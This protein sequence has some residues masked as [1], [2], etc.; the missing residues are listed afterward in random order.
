MRKQ[1]IKVFN[2]T[3]G[4]LVLCC[5]I[6]S[7]ADD[8]SDYVSIG[9]NIYE[10]GTTTPIQSAVISTSL[11][12]QTTTSDQNGYFELET[13]TEANYSSTPYTI[14]ITASGYTTYSV[15]H[16][17]GDHPSSQTFYLDPQ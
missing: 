5:S 14:T 13:Q 8:S 7:C 4:F 16:T 2:I 12:S 10:Q 1:F 9:G 6:T 15:Y 17:W 3:C 11:D